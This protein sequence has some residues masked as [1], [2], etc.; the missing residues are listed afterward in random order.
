MRDAAALT[1][2]RAWMAR[3]SVSALCLTFGAF[4]A[5]L[6][7]SPLGEASTAPARHS[8]PA[9]ETLSQAGDVL[10]ARPSSID[11]QLHPSA[12]DSLEDVEATE[13]EPEDDEVHSWPNVVALRD[14][15]EWPLEHARGE[16][17]LLTTEHRRV[18]RGITCGLPRGP[19]AA[20][21]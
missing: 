19:P 5:T 21:R 3:S 14:T 6:V 15:S 10:A 4:L 12:P 1:R 11:Q 7:F 18:T 17:W 2:L 9:P 8:G 20:E 16:S 13:L